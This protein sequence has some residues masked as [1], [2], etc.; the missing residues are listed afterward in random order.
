MV[1][2]ELESKWKE[3]E[4]ITKQKI[5]KTNESKKLNNLNDFPIM[6][7]DLS[8]LIH[9]IDDSSEFEDYC[10]LK[11]NQLE[12]IKQSFGGSHDYSMNLITFGF[13]KPENINTNNTSLKSFLKEDNENDIFNKKS[14]KSSLNDLIEINKNK[15]MKKQLNIKNIMDRMDNNNNDNNQNF[16]LNSPNSI[17]NRNIIGNQ[18]YSNNNI[19]NRFND[20][21]TQKKTTFLKSSNERVVEPKN[22]LFCIS[23]KN[24]PSYNKYKNSFDNSFTYGTNNYR[25]NNNRNN[26][27]G[28]KSKIEDNYNYLYNLYPNIKRKYNNNIN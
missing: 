28:I 3:I 23:Q 21:L 1:N 17:E 8:S 2:E 13:N 14:R 24:K 15:N 6:R 5:Q 20:I 7:I 25:M 19:L 27:M 22:D 4:Q 26:N 16:I 9:P 10:K 18:S 12:K 11:V